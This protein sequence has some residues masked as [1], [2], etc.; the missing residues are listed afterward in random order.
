M[1]LDNL[2]QKLLVKIIRSLLIYALGKMSIAALI[3]SFK[4]T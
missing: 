4:T 2:I 1:A 3:W